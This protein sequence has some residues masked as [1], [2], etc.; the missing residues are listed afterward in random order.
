V[1]LKVPL[2][3]YCFLKHFSNW[4]LFNEISRCLKIASSKWQCCAHGLTTINLGCFRIL[5]K[6]IPPNVAVE[7]LA[8]LL[9]IQNILD[10]ETVYIDW[11]CSWLSSVPPGKCRHSTFISTMTT[12]FH[13]LSSSLFAFHPLAPFTRTFFHWRFEWDVKFGK[14]GACRPK[15][16]FRKNCTRQSETPQRVEW[17]KTKPA[18]PCVITWDSTIICHFQ[19]LTSFPLQFARDCVT[20]EKTWMCFGTS[21]CCTLCHR[22]LTTKI[23]TEGEVEKLRWRKINSLIFH[24]YK[25]YGKAILV[26]K[27]YLCMDSETFDHSLGLVNPHNTKKNTVVRKSVPAEY[28][29]MFYSHVSGL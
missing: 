6:S 2:K 9:R 19:N 21:R 18:K 10:P 16:L 24:F 17:D 27:N 11:D 1:K 15:N 5:T 4:R 28:S 13:I 12:S 3:Y 8:L 23:K 26:T 25:N 29:L 20:R 22:K 14:E 7:W